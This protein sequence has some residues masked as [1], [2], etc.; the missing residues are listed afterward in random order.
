MPGVGGWE[1][2]GNPEYW[3]KQS[4][5]KVQSKIQQGSA[6]ALTH[7]RHQGK[8][9]KTNLGLLGFSRVLNRIAVK[10]GALL[11]LI[12][13]REPLSPTVQGKKVKL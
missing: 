10:S 13:N 1:K 2:L 11:T 12:R 8:H 9:K 4:C 7:V 5:R 6:T 3:A